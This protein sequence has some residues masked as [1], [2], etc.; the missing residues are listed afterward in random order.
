MK[1]GAFIPQGWRMDLYGI[2]V[3]KQWDTILNVASKIEDLNL[4]SA[5]ANVKKL[6]V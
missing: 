2:N 5:F 4:L 6:I 3:N 1:I